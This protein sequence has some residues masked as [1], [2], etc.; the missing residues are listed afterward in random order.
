MA[1]AIGEAKLI[2]GEWRLKITK[3]GSWTFRVENK[4][5]A[6]PIAV[7]MMRK[8]Q[9]EWDDE[10][11]TLREVWRQEDHPFCQMMNVFRE[12]CKLIIGHFLMFDLGFLEASLPQ[13]EMLFGKR[14]PVMFCTKQAALAHTKNTSLVEVHRLAKEKH[15]LI[16]EA[17]EMTELK[18]HTA[19]GDLLMT[20]GVFQSCQLNLDNVK[21]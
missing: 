10:S 18:A 4:D 1:L 11:P 21:L 19:L 6:D 20:W 9:V 15:P 14:R 7:E 2:D 12:Q 16:R 5:K 8:N 3:T 17:E 13:E